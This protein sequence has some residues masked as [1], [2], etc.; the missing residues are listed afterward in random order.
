MRAAQRRFN[1]LASLFLGFVSIALLA[2]ADKAAE[3]NRLPPPVTDKVDFA[4][5]IQPLFAARCYRCHG[6][7][8]Q[9]GGLGLHRREPARAGGDSGPAFIPGKSGQSRLVRYVSG[10][11]RDHVMPP[12]GKGERLT[13]REIGLLRAWIDQGASWPQSADLRVASEHWAYRRPVRPPLPAVK[14]RQWARN[15]IDF[16]VLARLEKEGLQPAAEAER[17]ALIRRVSLDLIGLPPSVAEVDAFLK[18]TSPDAYER[19]VDRLLASPHYGERWARPWLDLARYADTN[20]YEKDRPRRIWLWRDWVIRALN[21][22][23]PFDRFTIEQIAGDLLP[24]ATVWQKVATGF[25]RNSML[26]DEGGINAEEFRVVAVKDRVDTTATVWLGTTLECAQCHSHKFDPFSQEEYY[27]F[28]AFFNQTEDK[29]VGNGP[30]IPVRTWRERAKLDT[31][32]SEL[33]ALD[34]RLKEEEKKRGPGVKK[35]KD[36]IA[37]KMAEMLNVQAPTT[38]V[39]AELKKP[40]PNYVMLRGNFRQK[41][42]VVE[43]GTPEVLHPF[44]KDAPRNRLG[45][46]RWLVSRDNPLV[47]R[48]TVN[49]HWQTIFGRGLVQTPEDFGT[50]G[51]RPTH[52]ELLDWLAVDFVNTG[53]SMKRLHRLM[54]TSSTYRQSARVSPELLKR[55]PYNVLYSRGPRL[56]AEYET[57]RDV[58]LSAGGLLSQRIGGPSVMP[59]QPPGVWE[60]SFGFYDLPNFRWKEATGDSRY[61]RGLYIFL[62]RS[63]LYPTFKMFDAPSREVCSVRRPRTNTPLQALAT[64]N[65][66]VFV[67]AAGGLARRTLREARGTTGDRAAW[68]FRVC[69]S[70]QPTGREVD[71]LV[72]L[73]K[74]ALARYRSNPKAAAALVKH[75]RVSVEGMKVD[76]LAAWT[77]VANV[78]LNLDETLTKG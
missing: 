29:G 4:R 7:K 59:P 70:R 18:D 57:L 35:I 5:D 47:G 15:G 34:N 14:D 28:L 38:M 77:V 8:R 17:S 69:V 39:M 1:V 23:M 46:A 60:N 32:T 65:D 54:V 48:V 53:W 22:D 75:C 42:K 40:R 63:A 30:E 43:P 78:L 9:A 73:Y 50:Q 10:L 45:L 64:L 6:S 68:A 20:G 58:A 66:P 52:P 62:R 74:K 41:G 27:R 33:E 72:A 25:H 19:V 44:P 36:Q 71:R 55:D 76:E 3:E 61:R 21:E 24:K 16:F 51:D 37:G 67:E 13:T 11:D 12:S 2:G 49:R 31:I 26:N 56:R